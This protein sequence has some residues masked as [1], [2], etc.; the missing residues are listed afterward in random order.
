MSRLYWIPGPGRLAIM[1][2][3]RGNDWLESE[4]EAWKT[5]GVEVVVSLLEPEEVSELE[6]AREPALCGERGIA[7]LSYPIPDRGVPESEETRQLAS[8]LAAD[9]TCGRSLAIHC[10]AGIGRSSLIAACVLISTGMDQVRRWPRFGR[11][12]SWRCPT[13]QPRPTG[14]WPSPSA[15]K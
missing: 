6:L 7:F 8:R 3:P 14:S 4:I 15:S 11:H 13:P 12:A 1:A 10:R 9:L 2:R 5:A